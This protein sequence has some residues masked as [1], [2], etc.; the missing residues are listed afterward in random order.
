MLVGEWG[1]IR[2]KAAA[3]SVFGDLRA[4]LNDQDLVFANLETTVWGTEGHIPKQP[5]VIGDPLV[6]QNCLDALGVDIANL[7]NNHSFDS[8]ASGFASVRDL[9]ED[10]R[11]LYFGAGQTLEEASRPCI[12]EKQ[13]ISFGWSRSLPN[14]EIHRPLFRQMPGPAV[15]SPAR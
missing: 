9:L 8:Y 12:I 2:T 1:G 13:G 5:R 3:R 15:R 6:I 11:I 4:I 7:A 14:V 10:Q